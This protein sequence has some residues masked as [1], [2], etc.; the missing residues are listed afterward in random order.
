MITWEWAVQPGML[1]ASQ[2]TWKLIFINY[3]LKLLCWE[4]KLAR[5]VNNY[6][7]LMM[8]ST[9]FRSHQQSA[10]FGCCAG[11][12]WKWHPAFR[13]FWPGG[14]C[15]RGPV[16]T[17]FHQARFLSEMCFCLL[18]ADA[19]RGQS[20]HLMWFLF[21]G[22]MLWTGT[23]FTACK[24][25]G[26]FRLFM[27]R[28]G[29][30]RRCLHFNKGGEAEKAKQ[31]WGGEA[32]ADWILSHQDLD[33]SWSSV[34]L[35]REKEVGRWYFKWKN[36][37]QGISLVSCLPTSVHDASIEAHAWMAMEHSWTGLCVSPP[38]TPGVRVTAKKVVVEWQN[39]GRG[40]GFE[41]L[42]EAL[43]GVEG[44]WDWGGK[45]LLFQNQL[46][47]HFW[48]TLRNLQCWRQSLHDYKKTWI[49]TSRTFI[50]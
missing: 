16:N 13:R 28:M 5:F 33:K 1:S 19:T 8:F 49:A 36:A 31:P 4:L 39:T 25:C 50:F 41:V 48:C 45:K 17:N 18:P 20:P 27:N 15:S 42:E 44:L 46:G 10:I 38:C 43:G 22:W 2:L 47:S 24:S 12:V 11:F 29:E 9:P 26:G 6:S 30:E 3:C 32:G 14:S 40:R 7:V 34:A 23:N 37:A 35:G 21:Q